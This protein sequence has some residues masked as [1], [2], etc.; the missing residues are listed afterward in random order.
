MSEE[1]KIV[2]PAEE[3]VKDKGKAPAAAVESDDE[4]D[5]EPAAADAATPASG[6]AKKKKKSKRNKLKTALGGKSS[7]PD[8]KEA[9]L[10]KALGGLGPD[11]VAQLLE[12]NPALAGEL[13]KAGGSGAGGDVSNVA[14]M[15]KNLKLQEIMTG[16]AS[17]GKNVK[18]MGAYKFWSTQPVPKFG[19]GSGEQEKVKEGPIKVQTVDE[20]SKEP[21]PLVAGFEWCTV[22]LANN[23]E[24][25]EVQELLYGHYVEDDE[26]MFR[27]NY[28]F[29]I[30]QW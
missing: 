11:Q 4:A 6:A 8:D 25:K 14:D 22:D 23:D 9:Q 28:S 29:S 30:L 10:Q 26:A 15:L 3:E 17:S 2:P 19:D 13:Q 18:D 27:F 1:S 20:V 24:L 5:D 7:D 21:P 16:L 12:L